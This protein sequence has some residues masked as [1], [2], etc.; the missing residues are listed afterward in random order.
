[1]REIPAKG[2][3]STSVAAFAGGS[4]VGISVGRVYTS[5]LPFCFFPLRLVSGLSNTKHFSSLGNSQPWVDLGSCLPWSS[6]PFLRLRK[7][8]QASLC[9]SL[10]TQAPAVLLHSDFFVKICFK[11]IQILNIS[12][13][14]RRL[15]VVSG[16]K[17]GSH[18]L[19][20][21]R[22]HN[23]FNLSVQGNWQIM[24]QRTVL[25]VP[26]GRAGKTLKY[27]IHID[28]IVDIREAKR[29]QMIAYSFTSD[30]NQM[31]SWQQNHS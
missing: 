27:A 2:W 14:E 24:L 17:E 26:V 1:M 20:K 23:Q 22:S 4:L 29:R 19:R 18:L 30:A 8:S 25:C 15:H 10:R 31:C 13:M 5:L 6:F 21:S 7:S 11:Y 9:G 3:R 16:Q 28:F 12:L